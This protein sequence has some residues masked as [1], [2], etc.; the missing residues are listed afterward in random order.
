MILDKQEIDLLANI[1]GN[2]IDD[3]IQDVVGVG[4]PGT[5]RFIDSC[6]LMMA[7]VDL[8]MKLI[9]KI[10]QGAENDNRNSESEGRG[11]EDDTRN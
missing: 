10:M 3:M 8:V 7:K 6:R 9:E 5:I 11:R 2:H 1:F 4:N